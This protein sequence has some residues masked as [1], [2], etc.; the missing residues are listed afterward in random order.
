M[1]FLFH[2]GKKAAT[3]QAANVNPTLV[4]TNAQARPV[5][6]IYGIRKIG[7]TYLCDIWNR[8]SYPVKSSAGGKGGK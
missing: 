5:P 4:N 2:Q 6:V 3:Q 7:G 8:K 1:S